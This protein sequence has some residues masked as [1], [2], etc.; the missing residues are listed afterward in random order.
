MVTPARGDYESIPITLE[1]KQ[2]GDAWDPA[3][4]EAADE[5][6]KSYGAPA[7]MAIPARLHIT[8]Q[9]DDTLKVE[10][11]AGMQTRRFHF[12]NWKPQNA[13]ATW[14][15]DSIAEWVSKSRSLKVV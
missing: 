1:A 6:C 13:T 10:T 5:Q 7:L 14:Q 9:D 8:W 12:G 2:I 3:K 15:G 4:D 11:D